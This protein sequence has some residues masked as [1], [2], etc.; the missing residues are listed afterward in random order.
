M[1][2]ILKSYEC[3]IHVKDQIVLQHAFLKMA[4]FLFIESLVCFLVLKNQA[5]KNPKQQPSLFNLL[6]LNN[7]ISFFFFFLLSGVLSRRARDPWMHK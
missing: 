4:G 3:L 7:E 6:T 2:C 1:T 5:P